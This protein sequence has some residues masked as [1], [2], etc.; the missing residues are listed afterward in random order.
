MYPVRLPIKSPWL[1]IFNDTIGA[2]ILKAF[3]NKLRI[4][5]EEKI[6]APTINVS[7]IAFS[8]NRRTR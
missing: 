7:E 2:K 5:R 4:S 3:L 1:C 8:V 6:A